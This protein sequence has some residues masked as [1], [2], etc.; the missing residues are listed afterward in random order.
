VVSR[1]SNEGAILILALGIHPEGE[2][3]YFAQVLVKFWEKEGCGHPIVSARQSPFHRSSLSE[4]NWIGS[5]FP[6]LKNVDN[7]MLSAHGSRLRLGFQYLR[8]VRSFR[9]FAKVAAQISG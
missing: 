3:G 5:Y 8:T 7:A 6:P 1:A 2:A 4:A 9:D